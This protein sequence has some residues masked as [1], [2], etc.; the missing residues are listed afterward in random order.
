MNNNSKLYFA[1]IPAC[2]PVSDGVGSAI[3]R[4]FLS[5]GYSNIITAD[6]PGLDLTRQTEVEKFFEKEKP[7]G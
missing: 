5:E 7:K 4:K 3:N 6:Y 1:V 2:L